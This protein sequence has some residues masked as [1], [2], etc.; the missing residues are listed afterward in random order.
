MIKLTWP[1]DEKIESDIDRGHKE[2][3]EELTSGN[4]TCSF[5]PS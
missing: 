5:R 2:I 1:W 3:R 4:R